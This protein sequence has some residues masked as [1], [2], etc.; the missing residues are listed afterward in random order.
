M[1]WFRKAICASFVYLIGVLCRNQYFTCTLWFGMQPY[2]ETLLGHCAE[3]ARYLTK[4]KY[5]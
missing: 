3:L 1:K 4:S 5:I 2:D